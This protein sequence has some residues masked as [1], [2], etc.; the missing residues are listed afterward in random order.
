[1]GEITVRAV[2][3]DHVITDAIDAFGGLGEFPD[4]ALGR[5]RAWSKCADALYG[6]SSRLADD[7]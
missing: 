5:E 3:F 1:M 7:G 2:Q 6:L 4:D